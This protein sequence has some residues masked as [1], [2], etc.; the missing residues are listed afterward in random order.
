VALWQV[1]IDCG[2]LSR[3]F[4]V[5]EL[6]EPSGAKSLEKQSKCTCKEFDEEQDRGRGRP[7]AMHSA[8]CNCT[9][10][11]STSG[12]SQVSFCQ[13]KAPGRKQIVTVPAETAYS[14]LAKALHK[15]AGC[16]SIGKVAPALASGGGGRSTVAE[17]HTQGAAASLQGLQLPKHIGVSSVYQLQPPC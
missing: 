10:G 4:I 15:Q 14:Y 16:R 1:A 5:P 11:A 13:P 17:T 6:L 8:G 12:R 7:I 3:P 9:L 2:V